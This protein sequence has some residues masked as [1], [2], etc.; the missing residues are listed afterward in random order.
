MWGKKGRKKER[1]KYK[2]DFHKGNFMFIA[3]VDLSGEHTIVIFLS[4]SCVLHTS[5][6]F[7][8]TVVPPHLSFSYVYP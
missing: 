4:F 6:V 3:F 5:N 2:S 7:P 1:K 8:T